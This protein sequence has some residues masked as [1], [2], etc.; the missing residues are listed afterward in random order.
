A[1]DERVTTAA[2][3]AATPLDDEMELAIR[4][5]RVSAINRG[6]L[7]RHRA[8]DENRQCGNPT[9]GFE[10]LQDPYELLRAPHR[11]RGD[12]QDAAALGR[13]DDDARQS[14]LGVGVV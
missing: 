3:R 12:E 5:L 14:S 4:L 8:V 2:E 1:P 7:D 10:L 9:F 11:E 6:H 13:V